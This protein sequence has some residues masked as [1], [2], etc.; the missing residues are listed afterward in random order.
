MLRRLLDEPDSLAE[1]ASEALRICHF[2]PTTGR[3]LR[4]AEGANEDCEAACYDCL[5]SYSN[6]REH[7]DLDRQL[8]SQILLDLC[9]TKVKASP[10]AKS[11][12]EHLEM[13]KTLCDTDLERN[14]LDYLTSRGL[15]LP[16][17]AQKFF[18]KCGT[19]P[20]FSYEKHHTVIYVDG[21]PHDFADR[22]L[23]DR[24][25]TERMEEFGIT[26]V[27][28]GHR[29]DWD[30]KVARYPNIFGIPQPVQPAAVAAS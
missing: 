2:D 29:D 20:D 3:D 16:T 4:R 14:W 19:K 21:P 26:V 22:Q 10:T 5:M 11:F 6:Q 27:R 18:E 24:E 8:I 13:L 9:Q 1:V 7:E 23:R 28:F 15:K 17:A 12:V 25:A 30:A